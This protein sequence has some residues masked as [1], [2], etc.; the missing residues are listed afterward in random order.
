MG[1]R[2]IDSLTYQKV[3]DVKK[4]LRIT[5][6]VECR[7]SG[8]AYFFVC[9]ECGSD[10]CATSIEK[11][12]LY[13]CFGCGKGGDILTLLEFQTGK[14]AFRIALEKAYEKG[15]I[16]PQEYE[17]CG[18]NR[19]YAR[20]V[21]PKAAPPVIKSEPVPEVAL[22]DPNTLDVVYGALL[23]QDA[24]RLTD[25]AE[26]YLASRNEAEIGMYDFFCY[27]KEIDYKKLLADIQE[28]LP[29]FTTSDLAGIP[30]FYVEYTDKEKKQGV[31]KFVSPQPANL[32]LVV[33][34]GKFRIRGLQM[35]ISSKK[36]TGPRYL[37]VSSA[38]KNLPPQAGQPITG[39]GCGP[40]SPCHVA[41]PWQT[42]INNSEVL[43]TE[44]IFK[45]R[46]VANTFQAVCIS[47]Q[48]VTNYATIP[49]TIADTLLSGDY[50]SLRKDG[51]KGS[52]SFGLC[53]DADM[54]SKVQVYKSCKEAF[55][56]LREQFPDKDIYFYL[57]ALHLG[58]GID[59]LMD[60][61]PDNWA[62]MVKKVKG[63]DFITLMDSVYERIL[64]TE[65]FAGKSIQQVLR[66]T[67]MY[68]SL[69]KS[70]YQTF[71]VELTQK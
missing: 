68:K 12:Y 23:K 27:H 24:F 70:V 16:T 11:P 42:G 35:R 31:W 7:R 41:Y 6:F 21:K 65:P 52:Y 22:K 20:V 30:G 64:S 5:D 19:E 33:R 4:S 48:G 66:D 2:E 47:L 55:L 9:P 10:S 45:A 63:E 44:G 50:R 71:W 14:P 34:D 29:D 58:K 25:A 8:T 13:N 49:V 36:W 15:H 32:G 17:N 18:G 1:R 37:W 62:S 38:P 61:H 67:E 39:M 60:A 46:K 53:F 26:K 59:D 28:K 54:V 51:V 56:L 57:W 69:Q 40:G 43:I 3:W